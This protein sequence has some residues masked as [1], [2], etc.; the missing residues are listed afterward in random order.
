ML[1]NK[2]LN[3][4]LTKNKE[5]SSVQK[6]LGIDSVAGNREIWTSDKFLSTFLFDI[7]KNVQALNWLLRKK[8]P[9]IQIDFITVLLYP[10]NCFLYKIITT[11]KINS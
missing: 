6:T 3:F 8:K 10:S 2:W 4:F 1:S 5:Q 9:L 11:R 7:Y